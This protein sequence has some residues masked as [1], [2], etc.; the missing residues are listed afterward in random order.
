MTKHIDIRYIRLSGWSERQL[1]VYIRN[2]AREH[3]SVPIQ[4]TKIDNNTAT[5]AIQG[6]DLIYTAFTLSFSKFESKLLV[7]C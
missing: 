6:Y 3:P 1:R 7:A 4:L 2:S 5:T